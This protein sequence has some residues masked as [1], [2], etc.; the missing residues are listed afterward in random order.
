MIK[1]HD[2]VVLAVGVPAEC[3]SQYLPTRELAGIG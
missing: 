3:I 2:R 1:E